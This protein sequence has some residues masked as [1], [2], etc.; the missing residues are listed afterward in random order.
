VRGLCPDKVVAPITRWSNNY[1][2]RGQHFECIFENR[3]RQVWTVAVEGNGASLMLFREVR[4][5]GSETCSK[6]FT[7][8]PDDPYS[9]ACQL[10]QIIYVGVWA[11]DGNFYIAQ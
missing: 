7:V 5:H 1:V 2:V 10:R 6:A 4:K 3:T 8:L 9:F 11:H